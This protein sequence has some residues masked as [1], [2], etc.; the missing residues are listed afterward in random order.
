MA[1]T[2]GRN[3]VD[4]EQFDKA[5]RS[6]LR[7]LA[8][9]CFEKSQEEP[10]FSERKVSLLLEAQF[11]MTEMDR[12]EGGRIALR[13]L[14]LE[15]VVILLI[16]GEIWLAI[17]QGR[18]QGAFMSKQNGILTSLQQSTSDTAS[19]LKGLLTMTVTMNQSA[20]ATATTLQSLQSTTE[21]MNKAVQAQ[22]SLF[23]QP[24]VTATFDMGTKKIV[25]TNLGRTDLHIT[26]VKYADGPREPVH[27]TETI[28]PNSGWFMD[29]EVIQKALTDGTPKS[30]VKSVPISFYVA[31]EH[32]KRYAVMPLTGRVA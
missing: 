22:L 28:A 23:Y 19:T 13:D 8:K 3:D 4:F 6:E 16:G 29:A 15:I 14:L 24:S 20:S 2:E 7:N 31:D 21:A 25:I 30:T 27:P 17:K 1:F 12:R 18:E 10:I 32:H 11:Y 9:E 26:D 5:K